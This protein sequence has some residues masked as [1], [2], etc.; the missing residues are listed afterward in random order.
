MIPPG[1]EGSS[2][3]NGRSNKPRPVRRLDKFHHEGRLVSGKVL[4]LIDF[5]SFLKML[6]YNI[7]NA[8]FRNFTIEDVSEQF[9][10]PLI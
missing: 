9:N 8:P 7:M 4:Q 2:K 5:F 10:N 6:M 3:W 1:L